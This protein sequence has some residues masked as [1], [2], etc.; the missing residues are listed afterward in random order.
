MK[1]KK[2]IVA[3]MIFVSIVVVVALILMIPQASDALGKMVG[4][5]GE[6]IRNVA[7]TIV[8]AGVGVLLVSYG[9]TALAVP[10]LGGALI[11]IGLALLA[12]SLWPLFKKTSS[13][14]DL[15][16]TGLQKVA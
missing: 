16:K 14:N 12:Y 1:K 10:I 2:G 4:V 13:A 15:G 3:W 9:V 5:S 11:V 6:K 7:R 8:G